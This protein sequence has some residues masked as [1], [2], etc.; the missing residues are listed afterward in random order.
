[1]KEP[2]GRDTAGQ[3]PG[4]LVRFMRDVG[5]YNPHYWTCPVC[6]KA[7]GDSFGSIK[8]HLFKHKEIPGRL[9]IPIAR[10]IKNLKGCNAHI[11]RLPEEDRVFVE[12]FLGGE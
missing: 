10:R 1:M 2:V 12:N 3:N 9:A 8:M 11:E 6:K 5:L 7:V 4:P